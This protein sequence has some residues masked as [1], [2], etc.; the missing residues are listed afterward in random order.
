MYKRQGVAFAYMP[1]LTIIG[2][3]Y[4]IAAIFGAQLVAGFASIFIGMFIGKIRRFFPPIVSGTVVMSIGLS[5]YQTAINYIGGGSAA[6]NN[7]TFGSGKFWILAILTLIV[8]LACNLFGKGLLKASGMLIGISVGYAAAL[9]MGN[10][11]SFTD[12]QTASWFALPRPFYFGL[13]F[14]PE[15]VYKRQVFRDAVFQQFPLIPDN[16]GTA[17]TCSDDGPVLSFHLRQGAG[18]Y[19]KVRALDA[20]GL[21]CEKS[22]FLSDQNPYQDVIVLLHGRK[23]FQRN[24]ASFIQFH[25]RIHGEKQ[26]QYIRKAETAPDTAS[27]GCHVPELDAYDILHRAGGGAAGIG[28]QAGMCLQLA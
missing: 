25:I 11:V 7:W 20:H 9:I 27:H 12:L 6:Q 17:R 26:G 4:G 8:T 1:I 3:N 14:H 21:V 2:A 23:G 18:E 5:L 28:I 22:G 24:D 19:G 16:H 10:V 13:E 15:A